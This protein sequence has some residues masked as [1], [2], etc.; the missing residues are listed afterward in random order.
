MPDSHQPLSAEDSRPA[1]GGASFSLRNRIERMLWKIAWRVVCALCPIKPARRGILRLFGAQIGAG[2]VIYPSAQ[3]WLPRYLT[4]GDFATLG[5]GVE[6]YNMAMVS[7]GEGAIVSQCAV[8]CA[9]SH[10]VD[11]PNFQLVTGPIHIGAKAWIAAEAFIGPHSVIGDGA[12]IG[13]RACHFG[14]V[15]D[16]EI[17][18]GNPAKK[19][20][21][22]GQ[23]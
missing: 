13:A 2:A 11:D 19:L 16:W 17:W 9:G 4:M 18:A 7:L 14:R 22:R 1:M 15:P 12:V 3:I 21:S 23:S 20:R 10:D 5:P 6:C 8:L